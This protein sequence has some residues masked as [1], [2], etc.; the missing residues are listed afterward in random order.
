MRPADRRPSYAEGNPDEGNTPHSFFVLAVIIVVFVVVTVP[1]W[2][3]P[4][5][6][7]PSSLTTTYVKILPSLLSLRSCVLQFVLRAG[8]PSHFFIFKEFCR[9]SFRRLPPPTRRLSKSPYLLSLSEQY[10]HFPC[11]K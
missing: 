11:I 3:L 1:S 8:Q 7:P 9:R 6:S 4:N 10:C 5:V 2:G